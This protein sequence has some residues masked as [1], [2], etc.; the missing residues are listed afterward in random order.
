[1]D[2][3]ILTALCLPL[4]G[5]AVALSV[6][7]G[8]L[9]I[10]R[11]V[12]ERQPDGEPRTARTMRFV[13]GAAVSLTSGLIAGITVAGVGGRMMM[14]LAA[15]TSPGSVQ[16]ATTAADETVGRVTF[17]GS[18]FLIVAFGVL[19]TPMIGLA[20]RLV[21][22]WLPGPAALAGV[23]VTAMAAAIFGRAIDLTSPS[24][25]DFAILRPRPL[26]AAMLLALIVLY[27]ATL[28][29]THEWLDRRIP[30]LTRSPKTWTAYLG[31]A[32]S[33]L[34]FFLVPIILAG[35]L[36]AYASRV[37]LTE[38]LTR[39]ASAR[40]GRWV[41]GVAGAGAGAFVLTD[42]VRIAT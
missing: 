22:R 39:P 35:A 18:M 10:N 2:R 41:F 30:V 38:R 36:L 42:L 19:I 16:G 5:A 9:P 15:A 25:L 26:I 40:I 32:V 8:G 21:R 6:R 4:L 7:F 31:L 17:G 34:N 24:N 12:A 14:R 3:W 13:R 1:M 37:S 33:F 20:Y 11:G 28:G 27:G 29:A 23:T